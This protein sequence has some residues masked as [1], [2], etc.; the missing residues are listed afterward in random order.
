MKVFST[1][2]DKISSDIYL[3]VDV[4]YHYFV[5]VN[6]F[7][8]FQI[9]SKDRIRL[10][11]IIKESYIRFQYEDGF[12]YKGVPTGQQYID[13]DGDIIDFQPVTL[14]NHPDRLKYETSENHILI[15]SLR[16]AKSPALLYENLNYK[17]YVFSNGFYSFEVFNGWNKKYVLY[18]LRTRGVKNIIDNNI[19]RG[20]GISSYKVDD[21]LKIELRNTPLSEQNV[22]VSKIE[23]IEKE[24]R[25]LKAT[26]LSVQGVIDSVFQREFNFD[27]DTFEEL[28]THK[29]YYSRQ[30][31]FS[32]NPDLRFSVKYHRPAGEFVVKQL[33]VITDKRIKHF[34]AEPIVLGAS[35]SPSDFDE[36]GK[37]Y[38]VSMATIKT[39]EI[40]LDDTQLV[41]PSYYESHKAKSLQRDDIIIARSGVAIGKVAIVRDDF[42][43]IFADFTMRIRFDKSKYNPMF[44]YYFIR[45]KYFQYLI[46]IYKKGLQNQNI[47]PIV[48]QE[49]PIPDILQSKQQC[50]VDEIQAEIS[51]Q[52]DIKNRIAVL[53]NQIDDII[54]KTINV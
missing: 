2:F 21:L 17:E 33:A 50:I 35:I 7:N 13:E 1:S 14:D 54:M 3:R 26:V 9:V 20:I 6:S 45:S 32:N 16:S 46:E 19:Y 15:S 47:F 52:D 4:K 12:E 31:V 5:E 38:Y 34:L 23:P 42:D 28:K 40:E 48:M 8:I 27:Y 36:N 51:K 39:L 24:I 44:A 41:S 30:S 49:F 43:G 37:A 29:T 11:D 10:F 53:R 22:A 18:L 25:R